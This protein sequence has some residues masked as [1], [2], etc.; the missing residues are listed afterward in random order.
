[1]KKELLVA[2]VVSTWER[3][4]TVEEEEGPFPTLP[5]QPF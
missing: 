4:K 5:D 3:A 1:M 2:V